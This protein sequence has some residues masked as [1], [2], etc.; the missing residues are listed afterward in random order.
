MHIK[1]YEQITCGMYKLLKQN[2]HIHTLGIIVYNKRNKSLQ[3]ARILEDATGIL[4][5]NEQ[6]PY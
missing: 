3:V 2:T 4:I 5:G 1:V 6:Y